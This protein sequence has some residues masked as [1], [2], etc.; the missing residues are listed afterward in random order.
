MF[1]VDLSN[2]EKPKIL[3]KL[4]IPGFSD[5]LHFYGEGK[6]LGIGMNVEEEAQ[7]TD[8][9]KLSMF[10][11]SDNTDVKE[12]HKLVLKNVYSTDVS[13][14][15]KAALIDADRNIIGFAGNTEGGERYYLFSYDEKTGFKCNMSEEINGRSGRGARGVYI[16]ET[17]YVVCGNV[18]E[19][20]S[21]KD[22]KKTED[23][24][25]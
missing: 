12:E 3:G 10:D 6:L 25:L 7:V 1:S 5:Y 2:P 16:E 24:I 11:I 18:I 20:Y 17:L 4:K 19:A 9:V 22:Y 13:Y 14:D 15:Y 8:G 21:L 23:L